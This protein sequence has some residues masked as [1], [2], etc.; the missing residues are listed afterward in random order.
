MTLSTGN[1][2]GLSPANAPDLDKIEATGK[3][4]V[5]WSTGYAW[6]HIDINTTKFPLDDVK[7]RQAL[8]YA[9]DKKGIVDTLYFG[10]IGTTDLP[11]AVAQG[12]SWAY[13]DNYTKYPY[14]PDKAK[15]LLKEAGWDC[16]AMPCT[17]KVTE[18]GKEVTKKLEITLMT[19]DRTDRQ[20]WPR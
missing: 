15:A 3:Y 6:E 9:T 4:K 7:V 10:K 19:T 14:D 1:V 12:R 13:T 18:G 8:Y 17:K 5:N 2:G 20:R 11:S 16:T